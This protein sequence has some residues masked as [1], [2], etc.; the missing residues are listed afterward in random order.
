M[1]TA[2]IQLPTLA[3]R[4][5]RPLA[6]VLGAAGAAWRPVAPPPTDVWSER[7]LMLPADTSAA[8]G[9]FDLS[10]RPYWREPLSLMDDPEIHSITIMGDAQGGKTVG[11]MAMLISRHTCSPAPSMLV[12]PDQDSSRE[13]RDKV[14][15]ICDASPAIAGLVPP[16]RLRNDRSIDLGTMLCYLAYSGSAQTMRGRPCK[17]V[18]ATEVDVWRDD[19]R[20]GASAQLIK[21]RTKAFR[22]SDYKVVY[23]STPTDDASTIAALYA[24]SDRRKFHVPCPRCRHWQ[25]LRFFPHTRGPYGGCGGV[26]GLVNKHGARLTPAKA[27]RE[28]YYLCEKGCRIDSEAKA[29]MIVAGVWVPRG[30]SIDEASGAPRLVGRPSRSPRN[31]G[32]QISAL[33]APNLSFGDVAEAFLE[34]REN[35]QLRAFFNNWLG[36]PDKAAAKLPHWKKLGQR[37]AWQHRRGT[38]PAEAYFLTSQ[39]DVQKDRSYYGVRAWGNGRTSWLVDWECIP[40]DEPTVAEQRGGAPIAGD[41]ARLELEVLEARF[42]LVGK[43]PWGLDFLPVRLLGVDCNYRMFE[44][45]NFVHRARTRYGDRVRATRGDHKVDPSQLYRMNRVD[46]NARTGERYEGGLE[47]WGVSVDVFREQQLAL[48]GYP[49]AEPGGW[50]LTADVLE[51]GTDY[52]RQIV[53]Q[54]PQITVS[55]AGKKVRRW[56]TRDPA[57]GE[58]YWDIEVL[59]LALAHMITGGE[60][61]LDK[62]APPVPPV[63][64]KDAAAH[65]LLAARDNIGESFA[66]R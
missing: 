39:A 42:P 63:E 48:F 64:P 47:L 2:N 9:P 29:E 19:P 49:P 57:L 56:V 5:Q 46:T 14:Y 1:V 58:H 23:E 38:V 8:P 54:G 11:L 30:Q 53:N 15:G 20:L 55:P 28:A 12:T 17:F 10:R 26:A 60:W 32:F 33:Y 3:A 18:F 27:R 51:L 36:L 59:Q 66:A 24:H 61:D 45:H 37:L 43:N 65:P 35:N 22:E 7:N 13:L 52:L 31:A 21:A 34:H 62:F 25:E 6:R 44:V 4:F 16:P 50:R 40:K 41:L